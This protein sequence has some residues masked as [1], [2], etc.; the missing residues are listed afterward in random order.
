MKYLGTFGSTT[1]APNVALGLA[2]VGWL[3]I[4]WGG[5]SQLGD[6]SPTTP[7][8]QLEAARD[9]SLSFMVAGVIVLIASAWLSGRSFQTAR[10][11]SS[12]TMG[13]IIVPFLGFFAQALG[14]R[15]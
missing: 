9:V 14:A 2:V 10:I 3:M 15:I 6:P 1:L 4:V 8:R 11:R 12:L 13:V 7:Q 5:L